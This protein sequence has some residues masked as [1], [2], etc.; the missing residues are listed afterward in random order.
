MVFIQNVKFIRE[1]L[2]VLKMGETDMSQVQ[3]APAA[4]EK[5]A[6][7]PQV[8][9]SI[10]TWGSCRRG[11]LVIIYPKLIDLERWTWREGVHEV[12]IPGICKIK[13]ENSDSR[14]NLNRRVEIVDVYTTIV[15][16]NYGRVSCSH[17]FERIYIVSKKDNKLIYEKPIV[18]TE[19][20]VEERGKY[21]VTLEKRY[22]EVNGVK[23][24]ID[25]SE[26]EKEVCIEKLKVTIKKQNDRIIAA[27][28]TYHV[29]EKLKEHGMRWDPVSKAWYAAA[30]K[31]DVNSLV[32]DLEQLGVQVEVQ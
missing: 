13:Y 20:A 5:A 4:G 18:K 2:H 8:V 1:Y 27:G 24:Y 6:P 31:V 11:Y 26:L 21:R 12:E 25:T 17:G 23:V 14:K 19:V 7:E 28:D 32:L 30:E 16:R 15:I 22:V 10:F 9:F 29:K 3:I